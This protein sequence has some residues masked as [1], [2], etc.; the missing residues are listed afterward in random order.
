LRPIEEDVA[1]VEGAMLS[2]AP[3]VNARGEGTV[4]NAISGAIVMAK[5]DATREFAREAAKTFVATAAGAD[6]DTL[7]LDHFGIE[8]L[9][10]T[11]AVG[12]LVANRT[13]G[14]AATIPAGAVFLDPFGSEW[15]VTATTSV[16][17]SSAVIPVRCLKA[18]TGTN[19]RPG[20][21][22]VPKEGSG[23]LELMGAAS[24]INALPMAGGNEAEG[25][26]DFRARIGLWWQSL[27]RATVSAIRFVALSVP[28]VRRAT[29]S[30]EHARPERGGYIEL[31][32]SDSA[33]TVNPTLLARVR[34]AV[35]LDG[36]AAGVMVNIYGAAVAMVPIRISL[37]QKAGT[38]AEV[39]GR[40]VEAILGYVNSLPIGE[41]LRRAR[42]AAEALKADSAVLNCEVRQPQADLVAGRGQVIRTRIEDITIQ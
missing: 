15:S 8:R 37:V 31:F 9:G 4:V 21:V 25:D 5:R 30:E 19:R 1:L 13:G 7:A 16:V 41:P 32:V 39:V 6:L 18:G 28:E 42:I 33:D 36:R 40:A 27:R 3:Q 34:S 23:W 35:D 11:A 14:S 10:A 24:Y 2:R 38:G 26:A 17:A 20:I 29:I 12:D 22:F